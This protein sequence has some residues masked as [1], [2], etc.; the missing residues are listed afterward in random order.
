MKE[1]KMCAGSEFIEA[2]CRKYEEIKVNYQSFQK[3]LGIK[4]SKIS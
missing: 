3:L 4:E 2:F 1:L